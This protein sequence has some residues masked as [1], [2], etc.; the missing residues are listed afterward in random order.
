[1]VDDNKYYVIELLNHPNNENGSY[2]CVPKSWVKL[3]RSQQV[4]VL[5]PTEDIETTLKRIEN[6]ENYQTSW[7]LYRGTLKYITGTFI[8]WL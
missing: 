7:P 8:N 6:G 5:Y 1:M 4:F 2:V 3:H